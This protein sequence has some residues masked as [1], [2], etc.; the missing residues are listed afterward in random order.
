MRT[1]QTSVH[2]SI[3]YHSYADTDS[4]GSQAPRTLMDKSHTQHPGHH[5]GRR[6][7][8]FDSSLYTSVSTTS[9]TI[10]AAPSPLLTVSTYHPGPFG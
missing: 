7:P 8:A 5:F 9:H 6:F 2:D 3:A 10:F 1:S 4:D